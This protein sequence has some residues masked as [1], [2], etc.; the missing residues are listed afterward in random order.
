MKSLKAAEALLDA[1]MA[2]ENSSKT[3]KLMFDTMMEQNPEIR[4]YHQILL[5]FL[6]KYL[7]YEKVKDEMAAIYAEAF[8]E[9]ELFQ[10]T[11]FY[12]SSVGKKCL[13]KLP[14]MMV[15]SSQLGM[16]IVQENLGELEEM[17][18]KDNEIQ[19][20]VNTMPLPGEKLN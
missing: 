10:L 18:S 16:A 2:K 9:H 6:Q 5:E 3:I 17:I 4:P 12:M 19:S 13:Q 1:M 8:D 15:K 11:E 14:E 20:F 7:S